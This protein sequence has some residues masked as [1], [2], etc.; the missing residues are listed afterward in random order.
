MPSRS[1]LRPSAAASA[2]GR[3]AG[4]R[5]GGLVVDGDRLQRNL[6]DGG[7]LVGR[8]RL[9]AGSGR[10]S[11]STSRL[12]A[13][14]LGQHAPLGLEQDDRVLLPGDVGLQ[15]GDPV[16]GEL[17]L[18]LHVVG[19]DRADD[20]R[21]QQ[22]QVEDATHDSHSPVELRQAP[23]RRAPPGR[24]AAPAPRCAAPPAAAPSGR[25]D[26]RRSRPSPGVTAPR[27]SSVKVGR[28]TATP[29]DGA[30]RRS[31]SPSDRRGS[32]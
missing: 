26:W 23:A 21:R 30:S 15:R 10:R 32:A 5:L 8:E 16:G 9:R 20:H 18:V 1:L 17:R 22:D 7:D 29:G 19:D 2:P 31:A 28:R 25:A 4:Q 13:R 11:C 6:V 27:A 3:D 14:R 12:Q 24:A